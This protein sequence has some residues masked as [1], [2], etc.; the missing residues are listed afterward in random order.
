LAPEYEG[1]AALEDQPVVIFRGE[2]QLLPLALVVK[3][4]LRPVDK[5]EYANAHGDNVFEV[6]AVDRSEIRQPEQPAQVVSLAV[7]KS[8]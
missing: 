5:L 2:E 3:N 1:Y 6:K 4:V 7:L 8:S